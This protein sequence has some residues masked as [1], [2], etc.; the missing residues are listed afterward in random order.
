MSRKKAMVQPP[1]KK[2]VGSVHP[3]GAILRDRPIV[4][5]LEEILKSMGNNRTYT[6]IRKGDTNGLPY[7]VVHFEGDAKPTTITPGTK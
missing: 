5:T 6:V 7:W 1:P 2:S 4:P 3:V